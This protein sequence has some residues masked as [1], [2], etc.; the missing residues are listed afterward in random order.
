[1]IPYDLKPVRAPA[2]FDEWVPVEGSCPR[3][4][5]LATR[6]L[7]CLSHAAQIHFRSEG[8]L[9]AKVRIPPIKNFFPHDFLR[10]S[11]N[12]IMFSLISQQPIVD[13]FAN[14]LIKCR[15]IY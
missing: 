3:V 8:G 12:L 14:R 2:L 5:G 13:F 1:M 7:N 11:R 9:S 6:E 15:P 4:H 10:E